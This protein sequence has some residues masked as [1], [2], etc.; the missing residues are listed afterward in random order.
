MV[1]AVEAQRIGE[2]EEVVYCFFSFEENY[3]RKSSL[4]T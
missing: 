4:R 1:V 2:A 3:P